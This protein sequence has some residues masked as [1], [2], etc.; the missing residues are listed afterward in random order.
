MGLGHFKKRERGGYW[1]STEFE[2]LAKKVKKRKRKNM[3]FKEY[4]NKYITPKCFEKRGE[5]IRNRFEKTLMVMKMGIEKGW[6]DPDSPKYDKLF[7]RDVVYRLV[8]GYNGTSWG[9][10]IISDVYTK[11][12]K[13]EK[14]VKKGYRGVDDHI[15]GATAIGR[16]VKEIF[17]KNGLNIDYM[18]NEWLP[19]NLYLWATVKVTNEEHERENILR[20]SDCTIEEKFN[21]K[22]YV[23]TSLVVYPK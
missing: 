9:A 5:R 18:V 13:K 20:N 21:F 2:T 7:M 12:W 15:V 17:E 16:H 3:N 14:V 22:H 11:S 8:V 23:N 4:F 10:G 19:E 1:V 6:F